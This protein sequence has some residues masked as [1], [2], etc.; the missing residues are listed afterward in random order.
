MLAIIRIGMRYG[1]E[2]LFAGQARRYS[3]ALRFSA[4]PVGAGLPREWAGSRKT[5]LNLKPNTSRLGYLGII[6]RALLKCRCCRGNASGITFS[7]RFGDR[8]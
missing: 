8:A 3:T 7:G 6:L 2:G 1:F 5:F 4:K